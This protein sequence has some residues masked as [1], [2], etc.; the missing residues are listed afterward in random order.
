MVRRWAERRGR[1]DLFRIALDRFA[2]GHDLLAWIASTRAW[3]EHR[4]TGRK[5]VPAAG[6]IGASATEA[7]RTSAIELPAGQFTVE[8]TAG[9]PPGA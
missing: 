9:D 1:R 3:L 8:A 7:K 2:G 5:P 4:D 6:L